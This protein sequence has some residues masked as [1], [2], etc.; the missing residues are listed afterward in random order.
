M[1]VN[2][3]SER[4]RTSGLLCCR[5]RQV[6]ADLGIPL[7]QIS[8]LGPQSSSLPF[9]LQSPQLNPPLQ[10]PSNHDTYRPTRH[11]R[12]RY[13]LHENGHRHSSPRVLLAALFRRRRSFI[14]PHQVRTQE[15]VPLSIVH[16]S[17]SKDLLTC[18]LHRSIYMVHP[19]QP[20]SNTNQSLLCRNQSISTIPRLGDQILPH[21]PQPLRATTSYRN[22]SLNNHTAE[23][24]D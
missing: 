9:I 8:S 15:F 6:L 17:Q 16:D 19:S 20:P 7:P 23:G 13:N 3:K 10:P 2:K 5:R 18:V 22:R 4:K 12:Q 24:H 21:T 11:I 1:D 14:R